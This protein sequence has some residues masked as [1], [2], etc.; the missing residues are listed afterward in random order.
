MAFCKGVMHTIRQ[1]WDK[2]TPELETIIETVTKYTQLIKDLEK[3]ATVETIMALFPAGAAVE[4]WL[5]AAFDELNGVT[6][7]VKSLAEKIKEWL[8]AQDSTSAV[9]AGVFKIASL[10][11]KAADTIPDAAKTESFYDSAVQLHVMVNK[12]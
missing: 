8:D 9:N 6:D 12:A 10:A 4:A 5:N 3:T 7:T 1:I 2:I 11:T